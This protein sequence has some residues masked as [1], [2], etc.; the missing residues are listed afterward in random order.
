MPAMSYEEE[1]AFAAFLRCR[2]PYREGEKNHR[3]YAFTVYARRV[4][5]Q[6]H[7]LHWRGLTREDAQTVLQ[8]CKAEYPKLRE[9][10]DYPAGKS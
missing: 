6:P 5:G 2:L 9:P 1:Q 8:A 3:L 10:W 4:L 7:L